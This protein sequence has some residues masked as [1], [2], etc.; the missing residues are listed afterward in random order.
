MRDPVDG[1]WV[2]DSLAVDGWV[3]PVTSMLSSSSNTYAI[4]DIQP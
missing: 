4:L 3:L 2:V 1:G